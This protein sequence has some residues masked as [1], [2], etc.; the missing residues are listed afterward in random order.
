MALTPGTRLGVYEITAPLGEGGMGQVWRA[1]DTTL[2]RQVAIKILPDAFAADPERLARF[3]REAKT[4]ASLNHPHIAAIYA[5]E[6]GPSTLSAS[7]GQAGSGQAGTLALVMELVEGDD[8]SQRI[9][10]GA[11]PIE[12]ALP[13]AKQIA[14]ASK[15][16]TS[17]ASSIAI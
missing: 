2:G 6:S 14:E 9:A 12:E 13:I 1:T 4:L 5:V 8:L 15:P 17:R 16:R 11:L 7:S 10:R 3:E